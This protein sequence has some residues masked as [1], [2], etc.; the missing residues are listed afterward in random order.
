GRKRPAAGKWFDATSSEK[1]SET[2]KSAST[3]ETVSKSTGRFETEGR[4]ESAGRSESRGSSETAGRSETAAPSETTGR[5]ETA[6]RPESTGG[7]AKNGVRSDKA[8]RV[9]VFLVAPARLFSRS[10]IDT[11]GPAAARSVAATSPSAGAAA[12]SRV[13]V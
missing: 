12:A 11:S 9:G 3:S 7:F 2:R 10:V 6:R 4:F 5:S 1:V 8:F 13:P